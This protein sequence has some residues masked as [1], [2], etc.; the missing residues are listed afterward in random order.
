MKKFLRNSLVLGN[1]WRSETKSLRRA[2]NLSMKAT[3]F[4]QEQPIIAWK[5]PFK[6]KL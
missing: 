3:K 2:T 1:K 5:Q 6:K 4:L